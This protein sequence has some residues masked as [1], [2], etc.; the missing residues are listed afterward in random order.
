[1]AKEAVTPSF[2]FGVVFDVAPE[3]TASPAPAVENDSAIERLV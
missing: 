2:V 1:M 3:Q